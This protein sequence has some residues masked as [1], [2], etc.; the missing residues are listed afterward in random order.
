MG[1]EDVYKRQRE[2]YLKAKEDYDLAVKK[3]ALISKRLKQDAQLRLSLIHIS[4]P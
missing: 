4:T 1:K 3:H 2:E